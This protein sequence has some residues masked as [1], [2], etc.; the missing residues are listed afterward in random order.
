[1]SEVERNDNGTFATGNRFWEA[2]SKNGRGRIFET[3]DQLWEACVEYFVWV[4]DHP[5]FEVKVAQYQGVPIDMPVPKMRAMSI[6]GLCVFLGITRE[7][8]YQWREVDELK[9]VVS[10]VEDVIY[11]Q[12]FTG[13]AADLLNANLIGRD[14]G[15]SEKTEITG[16]NGGAIQTEEI[17][18][19]EL[20]R[21]IAFAL[22]KGAREPDKEIE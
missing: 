2:R 15:I 16:K 13:A 1:M 21:R 22:G 11:T 9:E 12:K 10:K 17:S 18:S 5:L 14:L 8:W 4:D 20:A 19:R 7:T 6:S 3:G